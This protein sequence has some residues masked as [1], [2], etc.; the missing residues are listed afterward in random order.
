M[1][2]V[3]PDEAHRTLS[4]ILLQRYQIPESEIQ[5]ARA[6]ARESDLRLELALMQRQ[7]VT[8][9]QMANA[10][11]QYLDMPPLQLAHFTPDE[12]LVR[13][14]PPRVVDGLNA[15]PIARWGNL[16]EVAM[17]DP[18]D[19]QAIEELRGLTGCEILPFAVPQEQV[20]ELTKQFRQKPA[21]RLRD[22]VRE[23]PK[24]EGDTDRAQ[25]AD[26]GMSFDEMVDLAGEAVVVRLVNTLL[27]E[28]L[29]SRASD[30][31][32]EPESR[33]VHVRYRI[34]G[35]LY[36]QPVIP[37]HLLW[38]IVSRI[39]ILSNLDIA[40]RRMPQDGRFA[41]TANEREA[42]VR[43][44]IIPTVHGQKVVLRLLDKTNLSPNLAALGLEPSAHEKMLHAIQQPHGMILVTGPT[45]SGKTTTLYSAVQELNNLTVNIV[46]VEDPVEYQLPR[47]NQIQARPELGLTFAA[48]LRAILRQDPDIVMVGEI[49]DRE[50]ATIA[51]EAAMTGHLVL[52]TLHTNDAAGAVVRLLHMGVEPFLIASSLLLAQAQ[53]IFR[54]LCPVCKRRRMV[55]NDVL[56]MHDIDPALFEDAAFYRPNG[57][58]RCANIGFSGRSAIM[59]ILPVDE[60]I[61]E[62]I[63]SQTNALQ[64]RRRA[65][66]KGMLTLRDVGLMRVRRGV[67]T[68]E[69]I[70]RVTA[71]T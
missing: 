17:F 42:D 13:S 55:P 35:V 48:G 59:E 69:E 68:I 43:V 41:I 2:E 44:S 71:Q 27:I 21:H 56:R 52:S 37:R 49:R 20:A 5:A 45:G 16:L 22:I 46:T 38:A 8:E 4:D 18:F 50:T 57:C 11:A 51:V 66:A 10:V 39:K 54:I 28:A 32:I 36:D 70:L 60:E 67:T 34:D 26:E 47:V 14:L 65:I 3:P 12:E 30:I 7:L 19:L 64:I 58:G 23:I 63:L 53:R 25:G 40:Q 24:M 62:L 1:Y 31:H 29:E 15:F 61:R 9:A 33:S 6:V